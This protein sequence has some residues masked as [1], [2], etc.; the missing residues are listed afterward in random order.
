MDNGF[1]L[2][3]N[4]P[5]IPYRRIRQSKQKGIIKIYNSLN[6]AEAKERI[7]KKSKTV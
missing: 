4:K 5:G 2:K 1:T 7:N 3:Y 6:P